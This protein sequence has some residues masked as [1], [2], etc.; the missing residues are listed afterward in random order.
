MVAIEDAATP[1]CRARLRRGDRRPG[2]ARPP[3]SPSGPSSTTSPPR[4]P[5]PSARPPRTSPTPH[6]R[7]S[8]SGPT[9]TS[10]APC[11][12]CSSRRSPR[13][14][15]PTTQTAVF[16]SVE[17]RSSVST[18]TGHVR[19]TAFAEV[20]APAADRSPS[21]SDEPT[22][23]AAHH[24]PR[25]RRGV[26]T[27]RWI[28]ASGSLG[29]RTWLTRE[30][31][32]SPTNAD[33]SWLWPIPARARGALSRPRRPGHHHPTTRGDERPGRARPQRPAGLH[34]AAAGDAHRVP[35][36][37]A[38]G[39]QPPTIVADLGGG[40]PDELGHHRLP[41]PDHRPAGIRQAR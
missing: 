41:S 31:A 6:A 21:I 1:P 23:T 20:P 25:R 14:A 32:T 24:R 13:S 5:R 16:C 22:A 40:R 19:M 36:G 15:W 30:H 27:S 26:P 17:S 2:S 29:P 38:I 9:R 18:L 35:W 3:R 11:S 37:R 28:A 34:L 12:R 4:R 39:H 7:S 10:C 33:C 8:S